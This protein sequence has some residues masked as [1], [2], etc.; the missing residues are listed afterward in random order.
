MSTEFNMPASLAGITQNKIF[1]EMMDRIPNEFDKTEG[2][3]IY[4]YISAVALEYAEIAEFYFPELLKSIFPQFSSGEWLDYH[5]TMAGTARKVAAKSSGT[6]TVTGTPDLA[7]E[8]GFVFATEGTSHEAAV[9]FATTEAATIAAGGTVDIA[10]EAVEGGIKGNV[11][12]NSITMQFQPLQG[13]TAVNNALAFTGGTEEELDIDLKARILAINSSLEASFVGSQADYKRWAEEVPG[14]GTA[15]V[16]PEWNGPGTVKLVLLD[17]TGAPADQTLMDAVE[18]YILQPDSPLDRKAPVGATLT[19]ATM[20]T[21]TINYSVI[22]EKTSDITLTG[23]S[24]TFKAALQRYYP[25]AKA[26]SEIRLT[27][28]ASLLSGIDGVLD[29]KTLTINSAAANLALDVEAYPTTGT[30]TITEGTV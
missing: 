13:I 10:A 23:I 1:N 19:I 26:Q 17:Q 16:K 12:A 9:L 11:G 27:Q 18:D 24:D 30:V 14:V 4:D 7:I 28:V 25:T 2:G 3:F 8:Q 22:V 20:T 5:A 6:L 15:L 29:F 21:T